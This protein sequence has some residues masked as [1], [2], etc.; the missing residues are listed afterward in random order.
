VPDAERQ[1]REAA[2][3]FIASPG[4]AR[5]L[6]GVVASREAALLARTGRKDDARAMA[7]LAAPLLSTP[8]EVPGIWAARCDELRAALDDVRT[9]C[10]NCGSVCNVSALDRAAGYWVHYWCGHMNALQASGDAPDDGRARAAAKPP[11]KRPHSWENVIAYEPAERSRVRVHRCVTC[12]STRHVYASEHT[13]P[14]VSQ[15]QYTRVGVA[16]TD[17]DEPPCRRRRASR[18]AS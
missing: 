10:E 17:V 15:V 9:P 6:A 4:E 13:F 1:A 18:R 11:A 16:G 8:G 7:E 14:A 12:G 2:L 3:A 5:V